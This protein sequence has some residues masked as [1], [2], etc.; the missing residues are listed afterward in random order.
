MLG[1]INVITCKA[2]RQDAAYAKGQ[3]YVPAD[4]PIETTETQLTFIPYYAWANR[5]QGEMTVWVRERV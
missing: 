3:L 2:Y 1:G 5:K 4:R